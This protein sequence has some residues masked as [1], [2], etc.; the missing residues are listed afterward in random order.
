MIYTKFE[1][2]LLK[3]IVQQKEDNY[4]AYIHN[5]RGPP[6]PVFK[7]MLFVLLVQFNTKFRGVKR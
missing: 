3:A 7:T 6:E 1:R 2:K 4:D 5:I